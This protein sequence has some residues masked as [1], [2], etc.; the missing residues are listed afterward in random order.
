MGLDVETARALRPW[1]LVVGRS[2]LIPHQPTQP[3]PGRPKLTRTVPPP[4][5][6]HFLPSPESRHT[7]TQPRPLSREVIHHRISALQ[8]AETILCGRHQPIPQPHPAGDHISLASR[9]QPAAFFAMLCA[10]HLAS[11]AFCFTGSFTDSLI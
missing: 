2:Q 1:D 10:R 4:A 5:K 11:A 7:R 3:C 8:T 9:H 6:Q